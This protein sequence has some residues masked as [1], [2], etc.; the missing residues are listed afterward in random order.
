M[1]FRNVVFA[2]AISLALFLTACGKGNVPNT[3][4]PL[5]IANTAV[6]VAVI[7][8]AY[9][10]TLTATGGMGPF[11]WAIVGGTL[12]SGITLSPDG[13]ISGTTTVTGDSNFTVQV[14]DSQ[15]PVHAV[16]SQSLKLTSNPQL[17]LTTKSLKTVAI[18]VPYVFEL[19]AT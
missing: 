13:V 17:S 10:F 12:P 11:T 3:I 14:T 8:K 4:E 2:T 5:Q 18:N 9:S 19:T 6:P 7:S 15:K 1:N 16:A